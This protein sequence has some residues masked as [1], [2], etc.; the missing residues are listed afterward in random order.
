L[1]AWVEMADRQLARLRA[2][3]AQLAE[4]IAEL[5]ALRDSSTGHGEG[6]DA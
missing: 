2:E 1:D 6:G 5:Q 3:Q 4:T